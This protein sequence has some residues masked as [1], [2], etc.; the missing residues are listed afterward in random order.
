MNVNVESLTVERNEEQRRFEIALDGK[1]ALADYHLRE[2]AD[3]TPEIVFPHTEV[4]PEFEGRGI[5]SKLVRGALDYAREQ[6]L[7]V[8]PACPFVAAYIQRHEEYQDL[9]GKR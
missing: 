2:A 6:G 5:G 4:P 7:R 1:V 8:V 9:V 3:G